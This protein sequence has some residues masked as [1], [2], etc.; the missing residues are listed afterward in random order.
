V[1]LILV[2]ITMSSR[3]LDHDAVEDALALL[4]ADD[5]PLNRLDRLL[6][7]LDRSLSDDRR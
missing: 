7:L 5:D 2:T 4:I 3:L 6:M 1:N